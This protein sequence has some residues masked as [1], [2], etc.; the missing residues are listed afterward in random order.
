MLSAEIFTQHAKC[1]KQSICSERKG[2]EVTCFVKKGN[3]ISSL[4]QKNAKG[5]Q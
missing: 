2:K 5:R 4:L 3:F 1:Y